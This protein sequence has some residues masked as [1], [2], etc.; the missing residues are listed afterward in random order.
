MGY[1]HTGDFEKNFT[2]NEDN[3]KNMELKLHPCLVEAK[4]PDTN[5]KNIYSQDKIT[6]LFEGFSVDFKRQDLDKETMRSLLE[7]KKEYLKSKEKQYQDINAED[8]DLLDAFTFEWCKVATSANIEKIDKMSALLQTVEKVS[9]ETK[10]K[11]EEVWEGISCCDFKIYDY[12]EYDFDKLK[13]LENS[14]ETKA[15]KKAKKEA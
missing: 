12:C 1:Q 4:K 13:N 5:N 7:K 15:K 2:L 3:Y 11:F 14:E 6:Q 9:E 8:L 10:D